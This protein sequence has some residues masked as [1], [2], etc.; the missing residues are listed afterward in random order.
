ML[1]PLVIESMS[2]N[3]GADRPGQMRPALAPVE[4][5]TAEHSS[6]RG[7]VKIDAGVIEERPTGI[8]E[9]TPILV[10]QNKRALDEPVGDRDGDPSGHVVIARACVSERLSA[11]PEIALPG[12]AFLCQDHETFQH[13]RDERRGQAKISSSA[14]LFE[15]EQPGVAEFRK[16]AARCLRRHAGHVGELRGSQRSA[17]H[18]RAK[19]VGARRIADECRDLRDFGSTVHAFSYAD[20]VAAPST[21]TTAETVAIARD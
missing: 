6:L 2:K 15:R 5:G 10:E 19:H 9:L 13:A 12:G 18:Q 14:L 1:D 8:S 20:K 4:T 3:G 11:A 7:E 21:N 16:M 17:I